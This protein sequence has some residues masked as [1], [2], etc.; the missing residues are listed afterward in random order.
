MGHIHLGVLPTSKKWHD[1]VDLLASGAATEAV[2][3]A[4]ARAAENDFLAAVRDPVFVEAMRLLLSI[5]LAARSPDFADALRAAGLD[6]GNEVGVFSLVQSA[7]MRLD[8]VGRTQGHRTDL[9]EL[10]SRALAKT[11][12]DCIGDDL[13][14]LFDVT[15]ADVQATVR[16]LSYSKGIAYLTRSFFGD[17]VGSTLSYWLDRILPLHVGAGR[18][19]ENVAARGTFDVALRQYSSEATRIIQ[20]FSGGWY[21]KVLHEQG[22]FSSHEATV[23]GAVALKKIT[24]ELRTRRDLNA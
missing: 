11:L 7:M 4:S 21:G 9:G 20:E 1:V 8:E 18:R 24:S 15:P 16:K 19:F 23:F 14:G 10:A 22:K 3:A 12:G 13:P 5:P 6:I 2:V 17:L